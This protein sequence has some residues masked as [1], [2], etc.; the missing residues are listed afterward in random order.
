MPKPLIAI[1]L[2]A[3]LLFA[4]CKKDLG[5]F[6]SVKKLDAYSGSGRFNQA[7]FVSATTGFVVGGQRFADANILVT[8]DGGFTW[9]SGHYPVSGK[10]IYGMATAPWGGIYTCG[11]D[12]KLLFSTDTGSNWRFTQMDYIPCTGISFIDSWHAIVVG[13]IS[14]NEGS[15]LYIDTAGAVTRRLQFSYQL[16]AIKMVSPQVGYTCGFGAF[17]KTTNGGVTWELQD[18]AGDNFSAMDIRGEGIWMCGV[19]GSIFHSANGGTNWER[20]RNG[21]DITLPKY[22]LYAIL[23]T[24]ALNGWAVGGDGRVIKSDDGGHHWMQYDSFTTQ[25]LRSITQCPNG[26]L[27]VTGDNGALYRISL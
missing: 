1:I 9:A 14:F 5:H 26:D 27:L 11:Y 3:S 13:G 10:G 8:K 24:S 22:N 15:M 21:N 23:F 7:L 6:Q 2:F 25:T 12:G 18:V 17:L 20:L 16:N 4:S 19:E